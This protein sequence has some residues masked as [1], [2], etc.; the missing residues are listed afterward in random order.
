[1]NM[2]NQSFHRHICSQVIYWH[3]N[4]RVFFQRDMTFITYCRVEP[5]WKRALGGYF[6]RRIQIEI[7]LSQTLTLLC[8]SCLLALHYPIVSL[9]PQSAA[10]CQLFQPHC[11]TSRE[12]YRLLQKR[13][14]G[15]ASA[16]RCITGIHDNSDSDAIRYAS[17]KI[18]NIAMNRTSFFIF[19]SEILSL[20][21]TFIVIS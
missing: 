20:S 9:R 8:N 2:L 12:L 7:H 19:V 17:N 15:S 3:I 1:M 18:H 6:H 11:C 5:K 13:T 10:T 21:N 4:S 14:F 16:M